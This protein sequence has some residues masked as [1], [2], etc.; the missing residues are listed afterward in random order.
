ML[1]SVFLTHGHFDHIYG[2]PSLVEHYPNCKVYTTELGERSLASDI[3]N[4][5]GY[6]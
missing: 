5:S 1:E 2:L 3:L 6:H 4:M